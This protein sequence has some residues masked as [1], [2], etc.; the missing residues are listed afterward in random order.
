MISEGACMSQTHSLCSS[1]ET[2]VNSST[3]RQPN[4]CLDPIPLNSTYLQQFFTSLGMSTFTSS[5]CPGLLPPPFPFLSSVNALLK[6]LLSPPY[7]KI[8]LYHADD[9]FLDILSALWLPLN[10][11]KVGYSGE[12]L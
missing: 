8:A 12:C 4:P 2:T 6:G 1:L 5:C 9:Q 7:H 11:V 3:P 10:S